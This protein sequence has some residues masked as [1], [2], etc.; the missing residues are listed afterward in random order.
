MNQKKALLESRNLTKSFGA[1]V[2]AGD[3]NITIYEQEIV[4]V[5]GSNGAGKTTYIN[6]VTGYLK[7]TSGEISFQGTDI[8]GKHPREVTKIGICRSFQI[9]QL[10]ME[11]S[12][13]DNM[14]VALSMNAKGGLPFLKPMHNAADIEQATQVLAAYKIDQYAYDQVTTL[15]QGVRKLLDIAMA[16]VSKPPLLLLDEPTSGVAIEEKFDLMDT[17]M[18]A[19]KASQASAMFVEHD[20]EIVSRYADRVIAFYDGRVIADGPTA[21][22]LKDPEVK[23]Y[24]I[25]E[26]QSGHGDGDNTGG[27]EK[28]GEQSHA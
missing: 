25:G 9:A 3:I 28:T 2:A 17:V 1:V 11:L 14:L 23:Q 18:D 20:M 13:M 4:G 8:T 27:D 6:M 5:I 12:V 7:P 10:F 21:E 16:M 26:I 15:P 24:V 19:V 22:V